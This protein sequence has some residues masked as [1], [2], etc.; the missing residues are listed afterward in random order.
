MDL[1]ERF[2]SK[3]KKSET[4][5]EWTG[6]RTNSGYGKFCLS[7]KGGKTV[8]A[9]RFSYELNFEPIPKGLFVCHRCD[10]CLCVRPDHLFL[11]THADNMRDMAE[12]KRTAHGIN[13]PKYILL[14]NRLKTFQSNYSPDLATRA[15]NPYHAAKKLTAS[16]VLQMR[17]LFNEGKHTCKDI[18]LLFGVSKS[19]AWE[20]VTRRIWRHI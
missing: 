17:A 20:V 18:S 7:G 8:G 6:G 11:G 5:W 1:A 13:S 4:C 9:H 12:K 3:V 19:T 14:Y 15:V 10:N 2:W 16:K